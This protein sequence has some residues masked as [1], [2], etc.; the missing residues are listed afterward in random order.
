[1]KNK[2]LFIN[3]L[4]FSFLVKLL[5]EKKYLKTSFNNTTFLVTN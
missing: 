4:L 2:I 3:A 5:K 1:M